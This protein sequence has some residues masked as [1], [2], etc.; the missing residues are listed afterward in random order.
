MFELQYK[1]GV[2][3]KLSEHEAVFDILWEKSAVS[4]VGKET[5]PTHADYAKI[6]KN[7]VYKDLAAARRKISAIRVTWG[8]IKIR[9][10]YVYV[11]PTLMKEDPHAVEHIIC[12]V[13]NGFLPD[14]H[15]SDIKLVVT[16][17]DKEVSEVLDECV[18]KMRKVMAGRMMAMLPGNVATP[19]FMASALAK[20]FKGQPRCK[21]Q[22]FNQSDLRKKGFGMILGVGNSAQAKPCFL[23]VTRK[24]SK[25]DSPKIAVVGKGITFD[26]GGLAVKDFRN[27]VDMKFDKIGAVYAAMAMLHMIEDPRWDHVT[28]IGA[29]PLAEN[30]ISERALHPGDVIKS[31]LGKSVEITNP[32]AEGRLVLGDALGYLHDLH[33]DLVIDIA[34]LTGHA[35]DINCWHAGYFFANTEEMKDRVEDLTDKIGERMLPMPTWD[36]YTDVLKSN[37]ADLANSP[38]ECGDAFIAALFLKEFVPPHA[39]WLH[40]DL[41]HETDSKMI[42]NGN[43]IRTV[44]NVMEDY[45][46]K[47]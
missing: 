9:T 16:H 17:Q 42:P 32:D 4:D 8:S 10:V 12:A 37:V 25:K 13:L 36:D 33:P 2:H 38:L 41:A 20:L 31:F 22:M 27:M 19:T 21:V 23:V 26:S 6:R 18:H 34:T 1:P 15:M 30:A 39:K 3:H 45:L 28:F 14:V 35:S 43:G 44:I 5:Y 40:I 46:T 11:A 24:G 29:F 47:K 7:K